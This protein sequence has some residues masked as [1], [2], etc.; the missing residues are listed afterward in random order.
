[1]CPNLLHCN[2]TKLIANKY[3]LNP[4]I[5]GDKIPFCYKEEI[6]I[7]LEQS[8]SAITAQQN[9]WKTMKRALQEKFKAISAFIKKQSVSKWLNETTQ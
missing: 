5:N 2:K 8:Y 9:H 7:L 6:K 1:M 3:V 4:Q